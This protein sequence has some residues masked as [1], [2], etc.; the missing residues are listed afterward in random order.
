MP[1]IMVCQRNA[2]KYKNIVLGITRKI[3]RDDIIHASNVI[4]E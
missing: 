1:I 4:E 3:V 2:Y